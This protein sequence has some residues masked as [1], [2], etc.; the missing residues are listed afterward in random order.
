MRLR[1]LLRTIEEK[2]IE[3]IALSEVRWHGQGEMNSLGFTILYSGLPESQHR[4]R[5]V[6][7]VMGATATAA[8]KCAGSVFVPVSE[9]I[10]RIRMRMH[11][12]HASLIAVYAPTNEDQVE[13]EQFYQDLQPVVS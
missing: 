3:C 12:G 2:R 11:S 7:I 8:W 6:A 10:L 13:S 1:V 4:T 5:G 9:R